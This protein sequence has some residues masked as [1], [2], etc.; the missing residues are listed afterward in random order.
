M[1]K[2]LKLIYICVSSSQQSSEAVILKDIDDVKKKLQD[3]LNKLEKL[4]S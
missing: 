3:L 4:Q 2:L 1:L